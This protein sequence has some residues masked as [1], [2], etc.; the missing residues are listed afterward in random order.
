LRRR[1]I[2]PHLL[3]LYPSANSRLQLLNVAHPGG[4]DPEPA[5]VFLNELEEY[6]LL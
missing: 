4:F 2:L 5:P 6:G 1:K 3:I